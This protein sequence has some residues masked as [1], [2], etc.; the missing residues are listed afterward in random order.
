MYV[1]VREAEGEHGCQCDHE[2][3]CSR[4][5]KDD[6]LRS[7]SDAEDAGLPIQTNFGG[8]FIGGISQFKFNVCDLTYADI[9]YNYN[10]D[11][12]RYS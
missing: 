3:G 1:Y 12:G 5:W 10:L 4:I 6:W 7:R 8:T 11:V 2:S 9:Q